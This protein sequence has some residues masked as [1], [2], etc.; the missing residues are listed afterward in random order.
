MGWWRLGVG[1]SVE[2]VSFCLGAG[3][4]SLAPRAAGLCI[5]FHVCEF[6]FLEV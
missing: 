5:S 1:V 6:L 2:E 3:S 4:P